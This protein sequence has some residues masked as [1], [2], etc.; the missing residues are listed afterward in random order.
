MTKQEQALKNLAPVIEQRR[1]ATHCQRGHSNW[2]RRKN[3]RR[4]CYTCKTLRG[5]KV[6]LGPFGLRPE[7][8]NVIQAAADGLT[9]VEAAKRLHY[10]RASICDQRARA[11]KKLGVTTIAHAVAKAFRHGIIN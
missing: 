11:F 6:V 9:V 3:G 10:Q 4:Y 5:R 2:R 1:T 8:I 7:E